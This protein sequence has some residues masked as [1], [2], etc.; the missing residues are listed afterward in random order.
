[1]EAL[2]TETGMSVANTS[3]HLH[4]L[5][6]ARLVETTKNGRYLI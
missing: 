5:Q 4:E 1:V 3:Q 2:A 6:E